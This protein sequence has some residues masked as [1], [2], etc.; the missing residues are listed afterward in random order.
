MTETNERVIEYRGYSF[1]AV[2]HSPGW[3][4]NIFP[5]PGLLHTTPDQVSAPT[6]EE[7]L[8]RARASVDLRLS[9]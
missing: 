1:I 3:R 8:A 9:R 5:G 4:V 2:E 6:K 7:A